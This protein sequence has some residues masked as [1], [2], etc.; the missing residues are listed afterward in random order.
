MARAIRAAV[1]HGVGQPWRIEEAHLDDP[2]PDEVLVKMAGTG[3]CHTDIVYRTGWPIP[4]PVVLGHEGAGVVESVGSN[5]T[6]THPG[7]HVV[8]TFDS[9]GVC[10]NCKRHKPSYCH[11]FFPRNFSGQRL[12]DHSSPL[13]LAGK[14]LHG[15]FFGQSS[16]ATHAVAR[17]ADAVV[18]GKDLPLQLL[19]PLGCGVQTGAG[20]V[21]NAFGYSGGDSLAIFG[22]G[23]VGLSALLAAR[24]LHGGAVVVVEPNEERGQLALALGATHIIN[25]RATKDVAAEIKRLCGPVDFAFDTTGI[26]AVATVALESLGPNGMLGLVGAPPPDAVLPINIMSLLGRGIGVK[27]IIEGSSNP[28][29]FIP[30]MLDWYRAGRFPFDRLIKTFR[31]EDINEAGHAAESGAVVKPVLLF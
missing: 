4:M 13:S 24:A 17:A 11:E 10:R 16:F 28:P 6:H 22:G 12:G 14:P 7:D 25:P 2:R 1:I 31:F 8:L 30:K 15:V 3:I 9:C 29:E 5:V 26:P 27:F 19:G 23:G 18:V 20:A 21:A